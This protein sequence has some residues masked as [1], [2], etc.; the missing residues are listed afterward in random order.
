M[1]YSF[2]IHYESF[3]KHLTPIR[4]RWLTKSKTHLL[5]PTLV[6][7]SFLFSSRHPSRTKSTRRSRYS[8]T[9]SF[10]RFHRFFSD[11]HYPSRRR[12]TPLSLSFSREF[13]LA[14]I[15]F[16]MCSLPRRSV[17]WF[18]SPRCPNYRLIRGE[19]ILYGTSEPG[20]LH[21]YISFSLGENC[22]ESPWVL[23]SYFSNDLVPT[24]SLVPRRA[25][26]DMELFRFIE[27]G[28]CSQTSGSRRDISP[29]PEEIPPD[30]S[31]RLVFNLDGDS[32]LILRLRSCAS[33]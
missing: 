22:T 2:G 28:V 17:K 20:S 18:F 1:K 19:W 33:R 31:H 23:S 30:V 4:P 3:Q 6:H 24:A 12:P 11:V 21:L 9:R 32:R 5:H 27:G 13:T 14:G 10:A 16:R 15:R 7:F 29:D 26:T 25:F 8:S